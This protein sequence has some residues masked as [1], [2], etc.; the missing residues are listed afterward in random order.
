MILRY[1]GGRLSFPE[2]LSENCK[3]S[4]QTHKGNAI[5]VRFLCLKNYNRLHVHYNFNL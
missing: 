4:H 5:S 2:W 3:C 1:Q